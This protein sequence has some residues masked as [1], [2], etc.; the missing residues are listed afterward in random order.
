MYGELLILIRQIQASNRNIR[1]VKTDP[2]LSK[3]IGYV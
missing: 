3:P 2:L 1:G